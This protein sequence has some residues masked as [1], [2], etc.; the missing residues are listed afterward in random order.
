MPTSLFVFVF[1]HYWLTA[2]PQHGRLPP[3]ESS[4]T[5]YSQQP[6]CFALWSICQMAKH[7]LSMSA[8]TNL[9]L[10]LQ[11][12]CIG[13]LQKHFFICH[14][15]GVFQEAAIFLLFCEITEHK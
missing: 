5:A 8:K 2:E 6:I 3:R 4:S 12:K 13:L 10:Q 1:S 7:S 9:F 15:P 14:A 11:H